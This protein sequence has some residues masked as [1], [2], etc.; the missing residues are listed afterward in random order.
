MAKRSDIEAQI[1]ALN[2]QL[3]GDEDDDDY[4]VWVKND[5]GH[6]TKVPSKRAAGW[7]KENFGI[8]LTDVADAAD[9]TEDTEDTTDKKVPPGGYFGKRKA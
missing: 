4:E 5:K 2:D 7:L 1:A 9:E 8:S 6:E 3:Q